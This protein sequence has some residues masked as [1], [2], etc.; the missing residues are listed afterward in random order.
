M[1]SPDT[2]A[3][4]EATHEMEEPGELVVKAIAGLSPLQM[5]AVVALV[6][7]GMGFTTTVTVCAGPEQPLSVGITV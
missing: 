6:I 3:L 2:L 4:F 1:L 7:A 5:E